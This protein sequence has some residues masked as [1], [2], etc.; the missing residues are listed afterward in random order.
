MPTPEE[1]LESLLDGLKI[2][3]EPCAVER[4][5]DLAAALRAYR[6]KF[7]A[8]ETRVPLTHLYENGLRELFDGPSIT[9]VRRWARAE[10]RA[11]G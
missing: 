6:K 11:N 9:T 5:K 10:D 8:G 2:V 4:N 1:K 3:K 7:A